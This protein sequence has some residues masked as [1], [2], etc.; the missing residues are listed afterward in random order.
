MLYL[1]CLYQSLLIRSCQIEKKRERRRR[2]RR[3]LDNRFFS[4]YIFMYT[5][6]SHHHHVQVNNRLSLSFVGLVFSFADCSFYLYDKYSSQ[7]IT[8]DKVQRLVSFCYR[9]TFL[10]S[11]RKEKETVDPLLCSLFF[12]LFRLSLI[13][14]DNRKR[15]KKSERE[16][17]WCSCRQ[18]LMT[19]FNLLCEGG[20]HK[21]WTYEK[22]KKSSE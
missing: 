17:A 1:R 21:R 11:A 6:R 4:V 10:L 18:R 2:N 19:I 7:R 15:Q 8:F 20:T 14:M 13:V 5:I 3:G 22:E 12:T 16:T 9:L